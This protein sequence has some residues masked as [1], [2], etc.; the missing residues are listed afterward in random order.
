[1]RTPSRR[2]TYSKFEAEAAVDKASG[3]PMPS[4]ARRQSGVSGIP[5]PNGGASRRTS[6]IGAGKKLADLGETY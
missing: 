3:I 6:A 5:A 2:G 1:M 4:S